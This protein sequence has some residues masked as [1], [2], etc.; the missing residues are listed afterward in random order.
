MLNMRS[1]RKGRMFF[2][3]KTLIRHRWI[4]KLKKYEIPVD[5]SKSMC[6]NEFAI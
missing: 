4:E 5:K 3:P 2:V 1:E 6:Y